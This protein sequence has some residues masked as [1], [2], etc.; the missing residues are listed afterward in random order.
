MI[1]SIL[2]RDIPSTVSSGLA[3]GVIAPLFGLF[4]L[5]GAVML[6]LRKDREVKLL[7]SNGFIKESETE[8]EEDEKSKRQMP[9]PQLKAVDVGALFG[10][11]TQE[12]TLFKAKRFKDTERKEEIEGVVE[13][14]PQEGTQ[15]ERTIAV[16]RPSEAARQ[17]AEKQYLAQLSRQPAEQL[18]SRMRDIYSQVQEA[19]YVSP[20]MMQEAVNISYAMQEKQADMQEGGYAGGDRV[21]EEIMASGNIIKALKDRYKGK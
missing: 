10:K 6:S 14:A 17:E 20:D 12:E 15:L 1:L 18:Y 11:G 2:S 21:Q 9:I 8:L 16:E 3:P 4:I 13:E 5:V 19:G 7:E